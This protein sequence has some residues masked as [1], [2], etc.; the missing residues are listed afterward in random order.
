MF[1]RTTAFNPPSPDML[2]NYTPGGAS[3]T[4][5]SASGWDWACTWTS[6]V[7]TA[8][9]TMSAGTAQLDLY[10]SN[11]N[12]LI[13]RTGQGGIGT[14][15]NCGQGVSRPAVSNG[16]VMIFA[17]AF[18]GGTGISISSVPSG[19]SL[20]GSRIDNG[21]TISL[22]VYSHVVTDAASEPTTN[23]WTLSSTQKLNAYYMVFTGVDNVTPTDGDAGQATGSGTSHTAPSVT[24]TVANDR[25]LTFHATATCTQWTPPLGMTEVTDGTFCS[26]GAGTNADMEINELT[27]TSAGATG[28]QTATN[29]AAAVG[30]TKTIALRQNTVA[31][32]C[33]LSVQLARPIVFRSQATAIVNSGTQVTVAKPAGATSGDVLLAGI[34]FGGVASTS[35]SAVPAN[36]T[37]VR[38]SA[39]GGSIWT[40]TYTHVVGAG[41]PAN[42]TWT[43]N[44]AV[45]IIGDISAY[46]GVDTATPVDVSAAAT[47]FQIMPTMT[48]TV[49]NTLLVAYFGGTN[50]VSASNWT[51]AA[52]MF[53]RSDLVTSSPFLGASH[54]EQLWPTAGPTGSRTT[55][56]VPGVNGPVG[57][58][59]AL[60][61]A[62]NSVVGT[63]SISITSPTGPTLQSVSFATSAVTFATGD[64]LAITVTAPDDAVNCG[65]SVSFDGA[66]EPSKLTVATIVPEGIVGLLLLAPALPIGLRWWKRRR[67]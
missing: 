18:R 13:A 60:R 37:L 49:P 50:T 61:P 56:S 34:T 19:W 9:Q 47:G 10:L 57:Q 2:Q 11:Q 65:T 21:A 7:F 46:S 6:D 17:C 45:Q 29:D 15:S 67:P 26:Q 51:P 35:M 30:V 16:D 39:N 32:T 63:A 66:A 55:N 5:P 36:W 3:T 40:N 25:L 24:T 1:K 62:A 64:R 59:L 28:A 20:I 38:Q 53:E 44:Q 48:T 41:E 58:W 33:D 12:P 23:I 54:Q 27:L 43:I 14:S 8:G 52:G 22:V 4:C 42:Y 31:V